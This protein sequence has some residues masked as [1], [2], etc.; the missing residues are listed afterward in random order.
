MARTTSR[1]PLR[2]NTGSDNFSRSAYFNQ[3]T[4][5][6]LNDNRNIATIDPQS[7][8]DCNNVYLDTN[9]VL[10]SRQAF[11]KNGMFDNDVVRFWEVTQDQVLEYTVSGHIRLK[12]SD[13][14]KQIEVGQEMSLIQIEGRVF[15]FN[16]EDCWVYEDLEFV[17]VTRENAQDYIYLPEV[18]I[19]TDGNPTNFESK[20]L[21]TD[22]VAYTHL[23]GVESFVDESE[24]DGEIVYY[25]DE[26]G[27]EANVLWIA[28]I[29]NRILLDFYTRRK[30]EYIS[31]AKNGVG[32]IAIDNNQLFYTTNGIGWKQLPIPENR[33]GEP[34]ITDDGM[35]ALWLLP[36]GL[37][38][39]TLVAAGMD[40]ET[41]FP[42]WTN[43]C[44]P[45]IRQVD[46]QRSDFL[47]GTLRNFTHLLGL[48]AESYDNYVLVAAGPKRENP[49]DADDP[50]VLVNIYTTH[51]S[52]LRLAENEETESL[53]NGMS[54]TTSTG[55]PTDPINFNTRADRYNSYTRIPICRTLGN[56]DITQKVKIRLK[57]FLYQNSQLFAILFRANDFNSKIVL[58]VPEGP[59]Y[60]ASSIQNPN[61][62][63]DEQ[64][65]LQNTGA[66]PDDN[67][68]KSNSDKLRYAVFFVAPGDQDNTG[69]FLAVN[70]Y[71]TSLGDPLGV[72][73]RVADPSVPDD[74]RNLLQR[75][76]RT[77][78][79]SFTA[80][81]LDAALTNFGIVGSQ[82]SVKNL[83]FEFMENQM[84][85]ASQNYDLRFFFPL[86][87]YS[88][89]EGGNISLGPIDKTIHI[90]NGDTLDIRPVGE[91]PQKPGT[92]I[93][94]DIGE[95]IICGN[96]ATFSDMWFNITP[97]YKAGAT[98]NID[99]PP[100]TNRRVGLRAYFVTDA[101][102]QTDFTGT[103][104]F[105]SPT[106]VKLKL[107]SD[108]RVNGAAPSMNENADECILER[109]GSREKTNSP[110]FNEAGLIAM[111]RDMVSRRMTDMGT[112]H[113][114]ISNLAESSK[115]YAPINPADYDNVL[116]DGGAGI[117]YKLKFKKFTGYTVTPASF[118]NPDKS[119]YVSN[120]DRSVRDH[121]N[122]PV[123]DKGDYT[124]DCWF[125]WE[126][127]YVSYEPY[128]YNPDAGWNI[129]DSGSYTWYGPNST[130]LEPQVP[131][132]P[133]GI[134]YSN[135]LSM[136]MADIPYY[137]S[138]K[139]LDR[140]VLT[141]E[142]ILVQD[143]ASEFGT[144]HP[145]VSKFTEIQ[146]FGQFTFVRNAAGLYLTS[147]YTVNKPL[148]YYYKQGRNFSLR[149]LD[150]WIENSKKIYGW[151]SNNILI[152]DRRYNKNKK[153]LLYI[154]EGSI[155]RRDKIISTLVNF[156]KG[157]IG[158]F[159]ENE[160]WYMYPNYDSDGNFVGYIYSKGR[161]GLGVMLGGEVET[162][163]DGKTICFGT[164]RGVVG[165]QYEQLTQNEEQILIYLSD[166][167]SD[168]YQKFYTRSGSGILIFQYK[169]WIYFWQKGF[170]DC[171][172]FDIR[173]QSWWPMSFAKPILDFAKYKDK[174]YIHTEDGWASPTD[175]SWYL[176]YDKDIIP[177][178]FQ[179]QELHF[180]LINNKKRI[181]N[182]TLQS[183][184]TDE[185]KFSAILTCKNFRKKA[186]VSSDQV[187]EYKIDVVRTF[188]HRLNYMQSIQ[189]Q[190]RL[191][192]DAARTPK[193]QTPASLSA[194]IVKYEVEEAVR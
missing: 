7:F 190:Y 144:F 163:Y 21:A 184:E 31:M 132:T 172:V 96:S 77:H 95:K 157:V 14:I 164:Y 126:G 170:K 64:Y 102:N 173:S 127:Y 50:N 174:M 43:I 133:D 3:T 179:S 61:G 63:G 39:L 88:E 79:L 51:P 135:K 189:F 178:F 37:H 35:T 34:K 41:E 134:I 169:F 152:E 82:L 29:T 72:G 123:I 136:P 191:G 2:V 151:L 176:D 48:E 81:D 27:E 30:F 109:G 142:Y 25:E 86:T 75:E 116:Y 73:G 53:Y 112:N 38:A 194:T 149:V 124:I 168:R 46:G 180:G 60:Y 92:A 171:L 18:E 47:N 159:H 118:T 89:D 6:G 32:A 33:I 70:H 122:R 161:V 42:I 150:G 62:I 44:K 106:T 119:I 74:H 143:P 80:A 49:V 185:K 186:F 56:V 138:E 130:L 67:T 16:N 110:N 93:E 120:T 145:I 91:R 55:S 146:Y 182:I 22:Y 97:G 19:F 71:M 160:I 90:R 147:L 153:P 111:L 11:K 5:T 188:V 10:C 15:I 84:E 165:L 115:V 148:K 113:N 104:R 9:N 85:V 125:Y 181:I 105:L 107:D 193:E 187:L 154:P 129:D 156:A 28:N 114:T 183:L 54:I 166:D 40:G 177:W 76:V 100:S 69:N 36:S 13:P 192:N 66:A 139:Y 140:T 155:E 167:I 99:P 121:N 158:I 17:L 20:N 59:A 108:I 68:E 1:T 52:F 87:A 117:F 162:L 94:F 23:R 78:K 98:P 103:A 175:E 24:L 83:G 4:W 57:Q 8:N 12:N 58:G 131:N 128:T 45:F 26:N 101:K 65:R 137:I 141:P